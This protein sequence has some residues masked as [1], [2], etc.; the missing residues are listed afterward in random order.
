MKHWYAQGGQMLVEVLLALAIMSLVLPALLTGIV[1]TREGKPQQMQRLQATAFMREATEAVRSGRERSWVGIATNGQYHPEFSGG[2]WNLVSGGETFSG[3]SRSID[4]SSVYRDASNTIVASGT[5]DPSTKKI[6]VT[7][8]W[9]TPRVTTVDSTFY[10]TRHL[11]N[12][13]HLE[14]T[15]AEFNGG[16]K[17]NLVVTNVSGGEL[18]LIPGGSSDWCAPNLSMNPTV[19]LPKSGVANAIHAIEGKVFAGTGDNASG[20]AY[21]TVTLTNA[22]PPIATILNTF[23]GYKTNAAFGD[24]SYAY[25]ATDNNNKEIV[26]INISGVSPTEVGDFN[27][28]GVTSGTSIATGT[29]TGFMTSGSTLYSFDLSSRNGSRSQIGSISIAGTGKKLVLRGNYLYVVTDSSTTQLHIVDVSNPANMSVIGQASVAGSAGA[30]VFMNADSSRAYLVTANSSTMSEFFVIDTSTK[31]GD[32]PTLGTYSTGEMNPTGVTAVSGNKAIIVGTGGQEYQVVKLIT[33]SAP[34]YCG[35][36]DIDSGIRGLAS[37]LEADQDVFTYIITGDASSE[38][39]I[40][41]G[42]PGGGVVTTGTYESSTFDAAYTVAFNRFRARTTQ[43]AGTSI[44]YQVAVSSAISG[45]C[46]GALFSY[47]GP[48]GSGSTFFSADTNPVPLITV[49]AYENP[50]QCFRYKAYFS[51]SDVSV[52]PVFSDIT[53]NYS[54]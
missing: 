12:L 24:T 14:T 47:V 27:A 30:D 18:Q 16:S 8:S 53:I 22:N 40:I 9:T 1:A 54:P 13:K 25:L 5:V 6:I 42:D 15:E 3:F 44:T 52:T 29:S 45:S 31:T 33:E 20:V 19:N 17:T 41:S 10:L 51:T 28:P 38:L 2:L 46:A 49:G 39:K 7:V 48:D 50:G 26:I 43:P 32:R 36:L 21:A 35:G 11:D 34:A 4:V 37:V 23:D